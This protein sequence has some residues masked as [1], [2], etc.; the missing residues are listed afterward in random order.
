MAA[1][2][3]V[4]AVPPGFWSVTA[5][6]KASGFITPNAINRYALGSDDELK[7]NADGSF[8]LYMQHDNPGPDREANWLPISDGAFYLLLR[9]YAPAPEVA[10]GLANL[11]SFQAPPPLIAA[12]HGGWWPLS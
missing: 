12:S 11:A 2:I 6:D 3:S 8:T 10:A 5:Y 1:V 7:R 4:G 9:V